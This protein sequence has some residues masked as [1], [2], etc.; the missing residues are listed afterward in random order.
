MRFVFPQPIIPLFK[1]IESPRTLSRDSQAPPESIV[2]TWR[3]TTGGEICQ[4]VSR[5]RF[6]QERSAHESCW[7]GCQVWA[8]R[9][10]N[11]RGLMIH[12]ETAD[13]LMDD[14]GR[15]RI[16]VSRIMEQLKRT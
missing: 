14:D 7:A 6:G 11:I 4:Y 15:C 10:E 3:N 5:E 1:P 9:D 12:E 2:L 16:I 13:D 8:G